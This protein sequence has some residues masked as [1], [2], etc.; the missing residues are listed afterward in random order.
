MARRAVPALRRTAAAVWAVKTM[1]LPRLSCSR[2]TRTQK[3]GTRHSK[4]PHA[5]CRPRHS[6]K[7]QESVPSLRRRSVGSPDSPLL[8]LFFPCARI[9]V[10]CF[11]CILPTTP[12]DRVS[13][14]VQRVHPIYPILP[15]TLRPATPCPILSLSLF[16][17]HAGR[18]RVGRTS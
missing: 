8:F 15:L 18:R 1:M 12:S 9:A 4:I 5:T 13:M 11:I 17:P 10:L 14:A 2:T 3:A 7:R 6:H 16:G